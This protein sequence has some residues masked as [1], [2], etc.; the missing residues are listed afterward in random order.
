MY[1][2]PNLVAAQTL[3]WSVVG[4]TVLAIPG[5]A[6]V[7]AGLL[8][9]RVYYRPPSGT[10]RGS[11][12]GPA[13]HTHHPPPRSSRRQAAAFPSLLLTA[14]LHTPTVRGWSR[15]AHQ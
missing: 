5:P 7:G 12:V 9:F 1:T 8:P 6:Q 15:R 3:R 10:L 13:V 2:I 4:L 11:V 14:V